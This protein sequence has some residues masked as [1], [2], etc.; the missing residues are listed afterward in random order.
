MHKD[1]AILSIICFQIPQLGTA[2]QVCVPFNLH[3]LGRYRQYL[4]FSKKES[5]FR[6]GGGW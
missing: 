2:C 4:K 1:V 6:W 3:P 5:T